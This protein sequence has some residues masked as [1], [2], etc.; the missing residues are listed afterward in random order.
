M[1]EVAPLIARTRRVDHDLDLLALAGGD[2]VLLERSLA[3][4]RPTP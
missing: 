2:G 4:A 1:T 3:L